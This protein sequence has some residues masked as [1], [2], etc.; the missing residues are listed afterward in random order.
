MIETTQVSVKLTNTSILSEVDFSAKA[1][2]ICAIVGPNGSGK[3]TFMRALTG[4]LEYQGDILF[5]NQD[6]KAIPSWQ[7]A[8]H[9]AVLPQATSLSFPFTVFEVVRLGLTAGAAHKGDHLVEDALAS[10]G[11]K[12]FEKRFYQ[13]LSGGEKQRVQLARILVQVWEPVL[14]GVPCWL[15]LD[16]PVSSLDIGHQ[17]EVMSIAKDF[18]LRGGGVIAVMHDLNLSAMF[19]DSIALFGKGRLLLQGTPTGVLQNHHLSHAYQW[20]LQ[21]NQPPPSMTPFIL[22]QAAGLSAR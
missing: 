12:G 10:V 8:L 6:I 21:V 18:S 17:I 3:T 14:D 5:N 9:R 15:F 22:P 13:E 20:E 1:G 4:E 19:A 11:L 2:E 7:L 16:E